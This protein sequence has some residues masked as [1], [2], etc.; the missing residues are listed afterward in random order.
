MRPR[1]SKAEI[2]EELSND[3]ENKLGNTAKIRPRKSK[4]EIIEELANDIENKLGNTKSREPAPYNAPQINKNIEEEN[5]EEERQ[6]II[7][8]G[9]D[10]GDGI[11]ASP[12]LAER[13]DASVS[14]PASDDGIALSTLPVIRELEE[15]EAEENDVQ[16]IKTSPEQP[17]PAMVL[18]QVNGTVYDTGTKSLPVHST[19]KPSAPHKH[20]VFVGKNKRTNE[21]DGTRGNIWYFLNETLQ[22]T[23]TN[24][25]TVEIQRG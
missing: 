2:I 14:P 9:D 3:I 1:K 18:R 19:L 25:S 4:A 15:E 7:L 5:S 10:L 17:G 11:Y 22:Q 8:M 20:P 21:N 12:I 24:D 16:G 13:L 23:V 6:D